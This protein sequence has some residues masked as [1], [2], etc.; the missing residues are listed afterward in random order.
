MIPVRSHSETTMRSSL[1]VE[2]SHRPSFFGR[3]DR[4]FLILEWVFGPLVLAVRVLALERAPELGN[5]V[6]DARIEGHLA[7]GQRRDRDFRQ[8]RIREDRGV[9]RL[10]KFLVELKIAFLVFPF[11]AGVRVVIP[12]VLA[13]LIDRALARAR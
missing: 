7:R 8:F 2:I 10:R 13:H 11:L 9:E 4:A 3:F 1:T 5:L 12:A 6:A